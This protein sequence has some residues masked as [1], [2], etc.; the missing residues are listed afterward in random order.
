MALN[1]CPADSRTQRIAV[2]IRRHNSSATGFDKLDSHDR[3]DWSGF[4]GR[5]VVC[6]FDWIKQMNE[7]Y[8]VSMGLLRDVREEGTSWLTYRPEGKAHLTPVMAE[9]LEGESWR[10]CLD[11]EIA[12]SLNL[13][14]GRDYIISSM[15]RLHY[16][17]E[18]TR[19]HDSEPTMYTVEFYVVDWYGKLAKGLLDADPRCRWITT[20]DLVAGKLEDNSTIDPV[21]VTLLNK[22]R[23]LDGC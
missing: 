15:A 6:D 14:S 3:L 22:S 19:P 21:V 18:I 12:W 8:S 23:I 16:D 11:R 5:F 17:T 7:P 20:N 4:A 13:V 2:G 1:S 9:R 10:G